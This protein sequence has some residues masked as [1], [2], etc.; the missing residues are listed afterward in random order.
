ML[1]N[2]SYR[3]GRL[4]HSSSSPL[5]LLLLLLELQSPL[6]E[7]LLLFEQLN[8]GR[9]RRR[10]T[11]DGGRRGGGAT[12]DK[13]SSVSSLGQGRLPLAR[14]SA[15]K[16]IRVRIVPCA[17]QA[18]KGVHARRRPSLVLPL[19]QALASFGQR[20]RRGKGADGALALHMLGHG[21]V[22]RLEHLLG[23]PEVRGKRIHGPVFTEIFAVIRPPRTRSSRSVA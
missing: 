10:P 8:L 16:L 22:H 7:A 2:I 15:P 19:T 20:S 6:F 11:P 18:L 23:L 12:G 14:V 21:L 9:T 5:L 4:A 13:I 17:R 1:C 3:G